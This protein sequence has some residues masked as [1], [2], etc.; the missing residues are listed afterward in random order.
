ML[1]P[2]DQPGSSQAM[3]GEGDSA[4]CHYAGGGS[5]KQGEVTAIEVDGGTVRQC[6]VHG[7]V[8]EPL[9]WWARGSHARRS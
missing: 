6:G 5:R 9:S 4:D 7:R 3:A 8:E 1:P 2:F